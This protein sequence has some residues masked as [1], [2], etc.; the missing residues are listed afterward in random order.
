MTKIMVCIFCKIEAND[1]LGYWSCS[2]CNDHDGIKEVNKK[3][4]Y[5]E[6][7]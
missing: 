6:E 2:F 1:D 5:G 7:E 4:W 3:E